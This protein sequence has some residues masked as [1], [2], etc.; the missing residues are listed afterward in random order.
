MHPTD[1]VLTPE[2]R[3]V[4]A[5]AG[6]PQ[7]PALAFVPPEGLRWEAVVQLALHERGLPGVWATLRERS[8]F[9]IPAEVAAMLERMALGSR[10]RMT[11][12]AHRLDETVAAFG[13]A[14]IPVMLLKGAALGNTAYRS[15][16][17][18]QMG[19]LDLLVPADM[20]L[21]ARDVALAN[22]WLPTERELQED[23]YAG[24]HHLPPLR[25]ARTPD[26][27]LEIHTELLPLGNP[28]GLVTSEIWSNA[29]PIPG[30][31]ASVP[32]LTD[33]VLHIVVHFAWAHLLS[34][35]TWQAF[36]DLMQL[37]ARPGFDWS[38]VV[39]GARRIGA[40]SACYWSLALARSAGGVPV[41]PDVLAALRPQRSTAVLVALGRH[42]G[43]LMDPLAARCPSYALS[44][45]LWRSAMR[46]DIANRYVVMP[47][48]RDD[49][50][51]EVRHPSEGSHPWVT[52]H[53]GRFGAY[54]DYVRMLATGRP[55]V[56]A[57]APAFARGA[58]VS[59]RT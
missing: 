44:H 36:R 32:S 42:L 20:A 50:K 27:H 16:A 45:R 6:G 54:L 26:L 5:T 12:L 29:S 24:H 10:A 14:G 33:Q 35:G 9:G 58:Q 4:L 8:E 7:S 23:F 57:L 13:A 49:I 47:W 37:S 31:R 46:D 19:D 52:R 39:V 40:T 1:L 17:E 41:P 56:P 38:A 25:D 53:L 59:P 48:A 3:L 34:Q 43:M 18:R 11:W 30:L 28:F 55:H 2:T 22:G 15:L 21:V 51:L